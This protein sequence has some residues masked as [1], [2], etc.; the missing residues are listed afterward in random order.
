MAAIEYSLVTILVALFA[1]GSLVLVLLYSLLSS[2]EEEL[3]EDTM[4]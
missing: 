3:E 4:E 1:L 2:E